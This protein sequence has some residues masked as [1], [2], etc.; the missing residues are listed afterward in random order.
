MKPLLVLGSV[1]AGL[2]VSGFGQTVVSTDPVGFVNVTVPAQSD[3][4]LAVP[5]YRAAAFKGKIQSISGNTLTVAGSPDWA[6]NQ[7]VQALP[8]QTD[9]FAVLIATGVKEGLIAK[10]TANTPNQLTIEVPTGDDLIGI[11]SNETD[12]EG[13]T[14]DVIPHWTPSSLLTGSVVPGTN[15]LV[16]PSNQP[17]IN[18]SASLILV[19]TGSS[20]LNTGTFTNASHHP[21]EFGR[22]FIARNNSVSP[23]SLSLV[24]SVPMAKHRAIIR[25]LQANRTQDTWLG[26]HSPVPTKIGETGLGLSPGDNLLVFDNSAVGKNK[27][28]AQILVFTGAIWLD[29]GTFAN[30]SETFHL[31]PGS[32]CILRKNQTVTPTAF[33]W[34]ALPPYLQ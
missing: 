21:F 6:A 2:A 8:S 26:F 1:I 16:P 4:V 30:V 18:L 7:F 13:D 28:A 3:A 14:L 24:G 5:L 19:Y 10:I 12:G 9:T 20:W 34:S 11:K 33:V 32:G 17:G 23:Q 27:S 31:Q 29:T 25:T 22:A 15:L